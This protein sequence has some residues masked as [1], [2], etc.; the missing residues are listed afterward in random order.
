MS[1]HDTRMPTRSKRETKKYRRIP[2]IDQAK[3]IQAVQDGQTQESVAEQND[4]PRT[5]L[6]HSGVWTIE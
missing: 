3:M 6:E 5:T 2:R 4:V 1:E